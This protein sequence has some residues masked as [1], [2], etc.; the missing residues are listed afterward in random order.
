[1]GFSGTTGTSSNITVKNDGWFP[2]LA[3]KDLQD[4]YRLPTEYADGLL[5]EGLQI[6]MA[7]ANRQLKEWKAKQV[8]DGAKSLD[9]VKADKLGE[10]SILF[11][12]Y[13]R[14]VF[15]RAK[16]YLLKHFPT[17]NRRDNAENEAK[18]SNET[19][20]TFKGFA[21]EAI[22]EI[23]GEIAERATLI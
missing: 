6:A 22:S 5:V 16:A 12:Q 15:S 18:E 11:L 7:W 1:M 2:D 4:I 9:E 23:K 19:E 17:V 10:V 13:R 3:V 20:A 21:A 8:E 14:A